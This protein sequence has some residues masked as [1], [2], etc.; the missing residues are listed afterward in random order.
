MAVEKRQPHVVGTR[1]QGQV[2]YTNFDAMR[3]GLEI[4]PGGQSRRA[5]GGDR[6]RVSGLKTN[7]DVGCNQAGMTAEFHHYSQG[8]MYFYFVNWLIVH[9]RQEAQSDDFHFAGIGYVGQRFL[10]FVPALNLLVN[11]GLI[12]GA[13]F[14]GGPLLDHAT[15]L[16]PDCTRADAFDLSDIV[17][18]E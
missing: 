9:V 16:Q 13:N 11:P 12:G 7:K 14:T 1:Q 15:I 4:R 6:H 10:G 2:R 17:T 8:G 3:A 5:E 18:D